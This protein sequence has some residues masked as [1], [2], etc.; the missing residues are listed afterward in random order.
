MLYVTNY[1]PSRQGKSLDWKLASILD[2]IVQKGQRGILD[3]N[4]FPIIKA[5]LTVVEWP[6]IATSHRGSRHCTVDFENL[7]QG[8]IQ[9]EG[10]QIWS[11]GVF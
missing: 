10:Y 1:L 11:E 6:H 9:M 8:I 4:S 3:R 7:L 5:I 2:K